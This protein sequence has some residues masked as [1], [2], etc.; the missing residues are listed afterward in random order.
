[1]GVT[2]HSEL[3]AQRPKTLEPEILNDEIQS[4]T[5]TL[6]YNPISGWSKPFPTH[7]DAA[8]TLIVVF[9]SHEYCESPQP[10]TD[11]R[12]AFPQAQIIGCSTTVSTR[13]GTLLEGAISV[14]IIRFQRTQIR[15]SSAPV[16]AFEASQTIRKMR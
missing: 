5:E 11:I 4:N 6:D 8:N 15:V 2:S 16:P 9:A 14:G 10:L 1:M 3:K 7:L 12:H 13:D